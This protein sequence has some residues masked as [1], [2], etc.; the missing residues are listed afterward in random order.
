MGRH[1]AH[2]VS[3]ADTTRSWACLLLITVT[4]L[5]FSCCGAVLAIRGACSSIHAAAALWNVMVRELVTLSGP[6]G[7][8]NRPT[9]AAPAPARALPALS[10]PDTDASAANSAED[11]LA[12]SALWA[13]RLRPNHDE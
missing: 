13:D 8:A 7:V 9:G 6:Y 5:A 3:F 2:S 1:G 12:A 4:H 10:T 11:T